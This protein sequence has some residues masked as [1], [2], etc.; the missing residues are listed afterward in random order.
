MVSQRSLC[1]GGAGLA[2]ALL[3]AIP[4]AR[5][6]CDDVLPKAP[7]A[8]PARAVTADDLVELRDIGQPDASILLPESPLAVSPDGRSVAFVINRADLSSN[9]YCRA[10]V[11][12]DLVPGAVPRTIDRGGELVTATGVRRGLVER[13]GFP[14]L[15]VPAW[16]P[17]GEWVAY[18][19]RDHGVTQVWRARRSGGEAVPVSRSDADVGSFA[20]SQ[21]GRT[22]LYA[23][24]P[25]YAAERRAT[26]E[27]GLSGWEYDARFVPNWGMHPQE[28]GPVPPAFFAVDV[29]SGSVR[30]ASDAEAAELKTN[31]A[32]YTD[33]STGAVSGSGWRAGIALSGTSPLSPLQLWIE[34]P[35]GPRRVC[36]D[37]ACLGAIT[38]LWWAAD[39][40]V[41]WY[42]KREGWANGEMALYRLA[43]DGAAPRRVFATQDLLQGCTL[44]GGS[45]LCLRE[46]AT[47]PRRLVAIDPDSGRSTMLFDPNPEFAQIR[48][49]PVTRIKWKN[50]LG[51]EAWGD[52]ALPPGYVS[53]AK[54]PMVVVQYHSDGFLR[55]GTGDDYPIHLFAARGYAVLSFERPAYYASLV[56]GLR[57]YDDA[58]AAN[59]KDW[60]DRRNVLSS[61]ETG[62]RLAIAMGVA[63][64]KRIGITGLSDGATTARFAL[65]NSKLFSAA[66]ISTC[67]MDP[68]SVM[69][70]GGIAWAKD[71]QSEG[72]PPLSRSDPDFWKPFSTSVN[73][74]QLNVPILMQVADSE[75][76]LA[77]ESFTALR[78][79]HQ[80]VDLYVFPDE[81][82]YK[83]QPLH[84]RAVYER[85]VDWFDY[86]LR[87]LRSTDPARAADLQRWDAL[88]D[89]VRSR[90]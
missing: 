15:I 8:G 42:L 20:W 68:N 10:T 11:V 53:G 30:A 86:W 71:L 66:A 49:G 87:G 90:P 32:R 89:E 67:C 12:L 13:S 25:G 77:L 23:A 59:S 75:A 70:Y 44:G 81:Y 28:T 48:L 36:P 37:A 85:A 26:A 74:A 63:D 46:N 17:D 62:V 50:A 82:H 9:G 22:L 80:P 18:L 65:I 33:R 73:A 40:S 64:P 55:G 29:E 61:L 56:A 7:A 52:L 27:E 39:G 19:R 78:D 6:A 58:N 45:L 2:L 21:D 14:E 88:R 51:L 47:T 24:R 72:Y 34:P 16:S 83:W 5:A 35:G 43:R 69:T 84:R 57:S 1:A 3:A 79:H 76:L 54:L 41:L 38:G 4:H 31:D 60:A